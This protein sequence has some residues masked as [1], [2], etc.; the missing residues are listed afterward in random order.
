MLKLKINRNFRSMIYALL[1]NSNKLKNV[2]YINN[3]IL[4]IN[5]HDLEEVGKLLDRNFHKYKVL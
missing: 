2:F 4:I 1:S 3:D 5:S